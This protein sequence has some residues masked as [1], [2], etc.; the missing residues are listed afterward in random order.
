M[1]SPPV[2]P[3]QGGE[4]PGASTD[5]EPP[6]SLLSTPI[7]PFETSE[8]SPVRDWHVQDMVFTEPAGA[9]PAGVAD[10]AKGGEAPGAGRV[11]DPGV[12]LLPTPMPV[13]SA[14]AAQVSGERAQQEPG[15]GQDLGHRK[16]GMRSFQGGEAHKMAT[17]DNVAALQRL[18]IVFAKMTQV[19]PGL[20]LLN[21]KD[22]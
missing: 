12:W 14:P 10:A 16:G 13:P 15:A 7:V 21:Q 19:L 20:D 11:E 3:K 1:S 22:G 17:G 9:V 8:A 2:S 4:T 18:D 5:P 6:V